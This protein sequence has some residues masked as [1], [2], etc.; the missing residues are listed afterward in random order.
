ML[1]RLINDLKI[2][3]RVKKV[4]STDLMVIVDEAITN[5]T[6]ALVFR[7]DRVACPKFGHTALLQE[8]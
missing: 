3:N 2:A 1:S 7:L 8:L 6:L 4:S 5:Q